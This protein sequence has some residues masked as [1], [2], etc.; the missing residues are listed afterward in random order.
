LITGIGEKTGAKRL[1]Q[2]GRKKGLDQQDRKGGESRTSESTA[3]HKRLGNRTCT[4]V[5][6]EDRDMNI[7][8]GV[9]ENWAVQK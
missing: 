5:Q 8:K 9:L 6:N 2:S 7:R 3:Q 1:A 4:V